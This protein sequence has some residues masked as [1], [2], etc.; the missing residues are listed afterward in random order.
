[1]NESDQ[2][3]K[4]EEK[5]DRSLLEMNLSIKKIAEDID[6]IAR[7][8]VAVHKKPEGYEEK[9]RQREAAFRKRQEDH[10]EETKTRYG[11]DDPIYKREAAFLEEM[12]KLYW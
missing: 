8:L 12:K 4:S 1:M 6:F 3:E 10:L 9:L 2:N 7:F 11:K 5:R